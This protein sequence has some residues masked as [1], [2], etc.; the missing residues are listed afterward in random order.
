MRHSFNS[1]CRYN[2]LGGYN[3]AFG[4]R[5]SVLFPRDAMIDFI[6]RSRGFEMR[7]EDFEQSIGRVLADPRP[8]DV[9]YA[10]PPYLPREGGS[11]TQ[12][13][14]NSFTL[15][16]HKRLAQLALECRDAGVRF[17][18]SNQ[19][20]PAAESLYAGCEANTRCD[21]IEHF[22]VERR[23]SCKSSSRRQVQE[24]LVVYDHSLRTRPAFAP[25]AVPHHPVELPLAEPS[26]V[27]F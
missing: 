1:L 6:E 16:D 5:K 26:A 12:Y 13:A 4:D 14:G 11:F 24:L 9:V 2:R 10:D 17:V 19:S 3:V 7:C 22:D 21:H 20:V 25:V 18:I 23:I 15:A 27:L 8:G